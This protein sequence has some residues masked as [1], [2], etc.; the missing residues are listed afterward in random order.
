MNYNLY[1]NNINVLRKYEY[2]YIKDTLL[3]YVPKYDIEID[4]NNNEIILKEKSNNT[5]YK[6]LKYEPLKYEREDN[7]VNAPFI[8]E[9]EFFIENIIYLRDNYI[10]K[11]CCMYLYYNNVED[12][13]EMLQIINI[14]SILKDNSVLFLFG[15]DEL[16]DF[17]VDRVLKFP[18]NFIHL[19]EIVKKSLAIIKF[20]KIEFLKEE[21][22]KYYNNIKLETSQEK[23]KILVCHKFFTKL[24]YPKIISALEF[25]KFNYKVTSDLNDFS[26]SFDE[27]AFLN[28]VYLYKPT[29]LFVFNLT[30]RGFPYYINKNLI[31]ISLLDYWPHLVV[32]NNYLNL[33]GDNTFLLVEG[34]TLE[35]LIDNELKNSK[36]FSSNVI[37]LPFTCNDKKFRKY[38]LTN[39]ELDK[40][41]SD[42][43]ITGRVFNIF[44]PDFLGYADLTFMKSTESYNKLKP[45][46]CNLKSIIYNEINR[47]EKMIWN[48]SWFKNVL[49]EECKMADLKL[50]DISYDDFE[51]FTKS[52]FMRIVPIMFQYVVTEWIVD[53]GYNMKIWACIPNNINIKK[54]FKKHISGYLNNNIEMSKM[55]NSTKIALNLNPCMSLHMRGFEAMLSG[56][57]YL[58]HKSPNDFS[59][60]EIFFEKGKS[61]D[62][63]STKSELYNK[64]DYYLENHDQRMKIA[65]SSRKVIEN[66][67]LYSDEVLKNS[68]NEII[69]KIKNKN[70]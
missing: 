32:N 41:K 23:F 58:T 70:N 48:L 28:Y 15:I 20:N 35:N 61:I 66:N 60:I 13:L 9:D 62:F 51:I 50:A 52:L 36:I 49:I 26:S 7:Y 34:L 8:F 27:Y 29:A 68:I 47:T 64:L 46:Y 30:Y 2:I 43:C 55:Y 59:D 69:N 24:R 44:S 45:I 37:K 56:C 3:N 5:N 17:F 54:K 19:S 65:E 39:S 12:F 42:I 6:I 11:N 31:I 53:R 38:K 10:F 4:T 40:Y 33:I 21:I 67:K 16:K 14:N 1:Y 18:E 25:G 63:Y 57:F 22:N